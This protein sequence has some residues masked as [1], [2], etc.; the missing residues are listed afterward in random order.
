[1]SL[2]NKVNAVDH[3]TVALAASATT[4]GLEATFT[5]KDRDGNTVK[6]VTHFTAYISEAA[7]GI[8]ITADTYSGDVTIPSV[9]TEIAEH[10][11]KKVFQLATNAS[12]V[13]TMLAVDSANP[14]DQYFVACNPDGS[15]T[16]SAASGTNWEGD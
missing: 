6:A 16:V 9:G 2:L 15:I 1:M 8:G 5:A 3:F 12:G 7:T 13:C 11:S 10:V 14:T 4:D